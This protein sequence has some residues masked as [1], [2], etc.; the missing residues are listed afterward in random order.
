M[1]V[2]VFYFVKYFENNFQAYLDKISDC[3]ATFTFDLED[4]IQDIFDPTRTEA[5]KKHYRGILKALLNNEQLP[6]NTPIAIRTNTVL[7][8][9]FLKDILLLKSIDRPIHTIL[10]PKINTA[11]EFYFAIDKLHKNNIQYKEIGIFIETKQG[12]DNLDLITN[13]SYPPFNKIIFGHADYNYDLNMFPFLHQ[14]SIEYWEWVKKIISTIEHKK[15]KFINSPC[16]YLNDFSLLRFSLNRLQVLCK[17]GFGQLT[18]TYEQTKTCNHFFCKEYFD[19]ELQQV[20]KVNKFDYATNLVV[21]VDNNNNNKGLT[22][23][24]NLDGKILITPQEYFQ[25]KKYL[26]NNH[27][28][29]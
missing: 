16:F 2:N 15:Y 21:Q 13:I 14:D 6:I 10:L 28:K 3:N 1:E 5:L 12:L 25:A 26:E 24:N 22:I 19:I 18:L 20:K 4:S 7:S 17:Q 11:E 29:N 9:E 23:S 27:G 8:Q